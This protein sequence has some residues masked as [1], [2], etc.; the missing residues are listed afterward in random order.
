MTPDCRCRY[1]CERCGGSGKQ[2]EGNYSYATNSYTGK[3]GKCQICDGT[4][5]LG[6]INQQQAA[7]LANLPGLPKGWKLADDRTGYELKI[8][9]ESL[10]D[11]E[12]QFLAQVLN[13][14]Y[15]PAP[16]QEKK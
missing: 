11:A 8:A 7:R 15:P 3:A 6:Y 16:G 12:W 10:T 5:Y 4:G 9:M 13:T 1:L 2:E 14:C